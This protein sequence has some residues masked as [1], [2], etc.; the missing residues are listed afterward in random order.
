MRDLIHISYFS[1]CVLK[2]GTT[3]YKMHTVLRSVMQERENILAYKEQHVD[4]EI[5][6]A[7]WISA[8]TYLHFAK[9]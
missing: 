2:Q 9:I 3:N 6:R 7:L 8:K 4:D 5:S 1:S